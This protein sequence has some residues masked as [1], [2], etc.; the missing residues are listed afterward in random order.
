MTDLG[1]V[2]TEPLVQEN[3][4]VIQDLE[5]RVVEIEADLEVSVTGLSSGV[6]RFKFSVL[7]SV[8]MSVWQT[9]RLLY[10][11]DSLSIC[12][13]VC[14]TKCMSDC[15]SIWH[16]VCRPFSIFSAHLCHLS[17]C[18]SDCMSIP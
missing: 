18:L 1:V 4:Q 5:K 13:T 12:H 17:D 14:Q 3:L 11:S 16:T 10:V 7:P 8:C 15:Q 6:P 2:S 9:V